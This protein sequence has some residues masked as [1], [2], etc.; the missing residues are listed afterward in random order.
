MAIAK[1]QPLKDIVYQV[2]APMDCFNLIQT[3]IF[4]LLFIVASITAFDTD[5]VI[6]IAI[7]TLFAIILISAYIN[8]P[9]K[10]IVTGAEVVIRSPFFDRKINRKEI[11]EVRDFLKD[12]KAGLY[13]VR[14]CGLLG[15]YG[16][17]SSKKHHEIHLYASRRRNLVLI[18]TASKKYV[19]SPKNTEIINVLRSAIFLLTFALEF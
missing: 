4:S 16:V 10:I 8:I 18:T 7:F 1:K 17:F 15:C 9:K 11:L 6:G 2:E 12:D 19:I 5:K 13:G 3:I 14:S